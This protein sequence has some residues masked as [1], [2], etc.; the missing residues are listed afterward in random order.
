MTTEPLDMDE[1]HEV[2]AAA[3]KYSVALTRLGGQVERITRDFVVPRRPQAKV[4]QPLAAFTK[5]MKTAI[6]SKVK[7]NG[8]G[9]DVT[10][11]HT[12][13]VSNA[14]AHQDHA[15]GARIRKTEFL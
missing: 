9:A 4:E 3:D 8:R 13:T 11:Q 14:F 2:I 10:A 12:R 1:P 5:W 7:T 6:E 15:G